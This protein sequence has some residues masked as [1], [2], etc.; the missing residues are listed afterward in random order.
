MILI[1]HI[2]WFVSLSPQLLTLRMTYKSKIIPFCSSSVSLKEAF[3]CFW[4]INVYLLIFAE[5]L[6]GTNF[7][8]SLFSSHILNTDGYRMEVSHQS[9]NEYKFGNK[10]QIISDNVEVVLQELFIQLWIL[11]IWNLFIYIKNYFLV[12]ASFT[13]YH[14]SHSNLLDWVMD[15]LWVSYNIHFQDFPTR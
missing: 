11:K 8:H 14:V 9:R 3:S 2:N 1:K 7:D 5:S 10:H 12:P 6:I 13:P 4:S 15:Q